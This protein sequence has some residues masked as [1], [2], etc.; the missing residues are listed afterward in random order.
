MKI[1]E[2]IKLLQEYDEEDE[3][4]LYCYYGK[5]IINADLIIEPCGDILMNDTTILIN[6]DIVK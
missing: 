3:V 6:K 5:D 2:L 1:K 4:E